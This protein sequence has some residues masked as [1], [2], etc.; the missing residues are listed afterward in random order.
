MIF[1]GLAAGSFL[2]MALSRYRRQGRWNLGG[3]SRCDYCHHQLSW[4]ENIPLFSF[5]LLRGRC[6][7]CQAPINREY[8]LVEALTAILFLLMG[9][10]FSS[11]FKEI[12]FQLGIEILIVFLLWMVLIFDYH[13][14]LIPDIL[15]VLILLL[16][17]FLTRPQF[18]SGLAG[19]SFFLFIY[20]LSRGHGIGL[21]DAKLALVMGIWL[22][23]RRLLL[24]GYLAFI[25]GGLVAVWL[26]LKRHY[27]WRSR[28]AFGP[29]L[30]LAAFASWFLDG[31]FLHFLQCCW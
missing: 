6:R 2:E 12:S 7:Y 1:L 30:I 18:L 23:W 19:L 13:L 22:G 25:S 3:R 11:F 15:L 8:P 10:H 28:I 4:W 17:L 21:G 24:T 26:L 5:F 16:E 27:R 29:F 20:F 14:F 31:Y 9:A